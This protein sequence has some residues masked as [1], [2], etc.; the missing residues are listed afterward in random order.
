MTNQ[1]SN[2]SSIYEYSK[3]FQRKAKS[4]NVTAHFTVIKGAPIEAEV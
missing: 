4:Q 3:C 1:T 2:S